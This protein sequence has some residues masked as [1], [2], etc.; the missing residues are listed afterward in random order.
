MKTGLFL[1]WYNKKYNICK[2]SL[3]CKQS[4]TK[5]ELFSVWAYRIFWKMSRG[6]LHASPE[7]G[8]WRESQEGFPHSPCGP[9]EYSSTFQS[10]F[11]WAQ[12]Q[13]CSWITWR[14]GSEYFS[15]TFWKPRF[16]SGLNLFNRVKKKKKPLV[17]FLVQIKIWYL[18]LAWGRIKHIMAVGE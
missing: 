10:S 15:G 13:R 6:F 2:K 1:P 18:C 8:E 5:K 16:D 11:N 12:D 14:S 9:L 17:R 7:P 4:I 3:L